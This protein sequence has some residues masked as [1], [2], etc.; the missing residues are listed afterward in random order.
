VFAAL[1]EPAT[2]PTEVS[3]VAAAAYSPT[4]CRLTYQ[5]PW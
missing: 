3:V 2:A 4:I 1:A 5:R